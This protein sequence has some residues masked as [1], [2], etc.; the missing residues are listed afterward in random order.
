MALSAIRMG[1]LKDE[2][3]KSPSMMLAFSL[4][5]YLDRTKERERGRETL[6]QEVRV[7]K[8]F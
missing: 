6:E 7:D 5:L 1:T 2:I 8:N 3:V 4:V